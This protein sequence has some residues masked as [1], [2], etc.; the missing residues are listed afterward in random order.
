MIKY[1]RLLEISHQNL[2]LLFK[3]LYMTILHINIIKQAI[4]VI[5]KSL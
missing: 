2:Y 4:V 1:K 3:K 5:T